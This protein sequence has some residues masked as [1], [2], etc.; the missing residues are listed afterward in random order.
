[1]PTPPVS[2]LLLWFSADQGVSLDGSGRVASWGSVQPGLPSLSQENSDWRP[3]MVAHVFH[4]YPGI[5]FSDGTSLAVQGLEITGG[6]F[7]LVVLGRSL[8]EQ[9]PGSGPGATGRRF[10]FR[11]TLARRIQ[12]DTRPC[13][14]GVSVGRN[15]MALYALD[16]DSVPLAVIPAEMA[17]FC[18]LT[19]EYRESLPLVSLCGEILAQPSVVTGYQLGMAPGT[20]NGFQGIV[21][22]V[23]LYQGTL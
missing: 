18:P 8:V 4:G 7:T 20:D 14:V 21:V 10:L 15:G 5:Q 22:E 3:G 6:D 19:V 2:N 13:V 1:M 16:L 9:S 11:Q 17:V 12:G 23:L